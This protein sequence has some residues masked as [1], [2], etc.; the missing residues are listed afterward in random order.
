MMD[1]S[2]ASREPMRRPAPARL[3]IVSLVVALSINLL[4]WSG[5][6][7]LVRPDFLLVMLLY[8][9]M[10]ESRN[11][12][13]GW[14]FMLGLVMDVA[15]SVLLGQHALTYVAAVFLIQLLRLRMVQLSLL[16]QALHLLAI[17]FVAETL[18]VLL[19]LSMGRDF[20]GIALLLAPLLGAILWPFISFIVTLSRFRQRD[21]VTT[22][23]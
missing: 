9:A 15:D 18:N 8:W 23:G 10:H 13:Q 5:W 16:E 19:N 4:P 14:G 22:M 1:L 21:P 12:G 20:P 2:P 6:A 17:L 11:I 3:V 7:L